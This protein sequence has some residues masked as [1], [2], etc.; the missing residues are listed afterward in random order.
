MNLR[1]GTRRLALLLG[2]AGAVAGG[3]FAYAQLQSTMRQRVDHKHF[4]QLANSSDVQRERQ[5]TRQQLQRLRN[6]TVTD[7]SGWESP[8]DASDIKKITWG[9]NYAVASIQTQDGQTLYP[10]PAPGAWAYAAIAL[11]PLLGFFIPWGAV[12]AIG[13][14]TAGFVASGK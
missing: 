8:I 11:L 9:K 3:V 6:P 14:V 13:W 1:E 12:R 7:P 5:E 2:V 10:T 4:D